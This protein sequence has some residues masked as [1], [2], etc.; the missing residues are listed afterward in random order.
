MSKAFVRTSMLA[1]APMP[2]AEIG[3][4][5]WMRRNLVATPKDAIITVLAC[6]SIFYALSHL[7]NW[8]LIHAVWVGS[9]RTFCATIAQGGLQPEGWS[10]AC[11]AFVGAKF[12]QFVFGRYPQQ[13]RWRPIMVSLIFLLLLV[14]LLVPRIP[15]KGL[16]ALLLFAVFPV[17]GFFLLYGGLGLTIVQ[18]AAW[19]GLMV[20]LLLSFVGIALSFPLA[21]FS[22]WGVSQSCLW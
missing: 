19:G 15:G 17:L 10:G 7:T 9:D 12:E 4:V 3:A 5:A 21:F 6:V 11:W 22:R 18:T 14:P 2:D 20:T 16:N 1:P 8:L 13:E